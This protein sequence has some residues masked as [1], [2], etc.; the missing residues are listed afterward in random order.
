MPLRNNSVEKAGN[1]GYM[2]VEGIVEGYGCKCKCGE[3]DGRKGVAT[4]SEEMR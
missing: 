1:S 2:E 4:G 3:V